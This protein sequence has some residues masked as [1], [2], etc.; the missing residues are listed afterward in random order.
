MRL[1]T[2]LISEFPKY[3]PVC[4]SS[5]EIALGGRIDNVIEIFSAG[6]SLTIKHDCDDAVVMIKKM[7]E[8]TKQ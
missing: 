4:G 6:V 8:E 5:I 7:H 2:S 3:C 1:I